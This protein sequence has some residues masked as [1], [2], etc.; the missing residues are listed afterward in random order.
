MPAVPNSATGH[1]PTVTRRTVLGAGLGVAAAASIAGSAGAAGPAPVVIG[2]TDRQL[3]IVASPDESGDVAVAVAEL[4]DHVTAVTGVAPR[5]VPTDP[6]E[7]AVW[8]GTAAADRFD[9]S[10]PS[11]R[12]GFAVRVAADAV[13][14]VGGSETGTLYGVYELLERCGVRWIEPGPYGTVLPTTL[15]VPAGEFESAPYFVDR[16]LQGVSNYGRPPAGS[17]VDP[18]ESADWY[19]RHRLTTRAYGAHGIPMY[20]RATKATN[21]ELY[22][23]VNGVVTNQ[24]NVTLPEVLDRCEAEVR[25]LLAA[26]P[27]LDYINLGPADGSGFGV[28]DW[29]VPDRIDPLYGELVVTDRYIRFFNLLLDRLADH[30]QLK[31]AFYAY[32]LYMEPPAREVPNSRIVPVFAPIVVD[33]RKSIADADGWERR[34]VLR[35]IE[36]WKDLGLEWMFR[37]YIGNLADP[38]MPFSAARQMADEI[39]EYARLGATGGIRQECIAGWGHHGPAFYLTAKLMWDPTADPAAILR[40]YYRSAYGPAATLVQRYFDRLESTIANAPFTA[41]SMIEMPDSLPEAV[42]TELTGHLDRAAEILSSSGATAALARLDVVRRVHAFGA[43][44]L[45]SLRAQTKGDTATAVATLATARQA[46]AATQVDSPAGLR[47]A[48]ISYLERFHGRAVEAVAAQVDAYGP[49]VVTLPREWDL[50][51]DLGG[52]ETPPT[53]ADGHWTTIDLH[54]TWSAQ[55]LRYVKGQAWYRC[56]VP[57][58]AMP[59]RPRLVLPNVDEKATVWINGVPAPLITGAGSFLPEVFDLGDGWSVTHDN[60]FVVLINNRVLDELGTGGLYGT[61]FVLADSATAWTPAVTEPPASE[62]PR[63]GP[64]APPAPAG[65]A[66]VTGAWEAILDLTGTADRVGLYDPR[67]SSQHFRAYNPA[68]SSVDQGLG[69][70]DAGL[71]V[72][73]EVPIRPSRGSTTAQL[74]LAVSPDEARVWVDS[75]EVPLTPAGAE[76]WSQARIPRPRARTATIAIARAHLT[77]QPLAPH[78]G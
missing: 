20:P 28:T 25:R 38:G 35:V 43:V 71:V 1:S 5:V 16:V 12:S 30:P 14:V 57:A 75:V 72:R 29:D 31:L 69:R 11:D 53:A 62:E 66:P 21:P 63:R 65:A 49:P 64:S 33:R 46:F 60:T 2:S 56:T 68:L 40:D 4:V 45:P 10:P 78:W 24:V 36:D 50:L 51:V 15:A 23:H 17:P 34:Y 8:L 39:P 41:G 58:A 7:P 37:G 74:L 6:G 19:R 52:T 73:A 32:H 55:G 44:T 22:M 70:Y 42:M 13:T 27:D 47:P 61:P 59:G 67:I 3:P 54:H 18:L 26:D 76:G 48:G 77:E 9:L